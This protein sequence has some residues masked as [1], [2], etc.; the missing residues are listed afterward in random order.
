RAVV[1][2]AVGLASRLLLRRTAPLSVLA[3]AALSLL[4]VHPTEL[5]ESGFQLTFAATAGILVF[6]D[7]LS[8]ALPARSGLS[9]LLSASLAA[10][11]ATAPICAFWFHRLVPYG[12]ASNLLAV[13]LGSIAVVLG[14]ALLP[15]DLVSTHLSSAVGAIA[16]LAVRAL[17]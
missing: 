2:A 8:R 17:L 14:I 12:V 4:A 6:S 13:P 7:R 15:A 3:V 5:G 1:T 11:A 9:S 10:Q 16:G